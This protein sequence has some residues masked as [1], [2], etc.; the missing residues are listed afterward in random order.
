MSGTEP[1]IWSDE[2]FEIRLP[3]RPHVDRD[4]GGHLVVYPKRD[5]SFRSELPVQEAQA[6]AVLLQALEEAY[7]FA[8]RARGLDMVWLNIQDN[9]NWS[10]LTDKPR[11]FH[12]HLYGRCRTEHGQTPG[13]AL[14]FPDPHSA[15]Y[16]EKK[17]L[18]EGD[19]AAIIDRLEANIQ[20]LASQE[21]GQPYPL[22]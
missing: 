18:D 2:N 12:V 16:D 22:R 3:N 1:V 7:L 15:I 17:Q 20:K 6:L 11:H 8:M 10:L 9:G 21:H 5:V 14:V 19:I 13:Q 4:D